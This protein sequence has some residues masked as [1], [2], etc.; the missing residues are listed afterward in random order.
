MPHVQS[1]IHSDSESAE[2]IADSDLEDGELRKMLASPLYVHGRGENYGSSHKPTASGKSEA[3]IMQKRGASAQRT[4]AD[5]SRRESL[6]SNSSQE[7]RASGKPDA[8]FS[9]RS[10]EPGN[11]FESSLFKYADPSKL[12]RSLL[13]GNKDHLLSQ[14]RSELMRQGHQGGSLNSCINELQQQ[15]YAQGLELQDDHHGSI[16]SRREQARLQVEFFLKEKLLRDTQRR[17]I[18]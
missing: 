3:K 7:P 10:D 9:S 14:A 17:N 16:E 18:H 2:S 6:K 5:H 13:E 1:E 12:G 8:V 4:Q 15:A 11:P